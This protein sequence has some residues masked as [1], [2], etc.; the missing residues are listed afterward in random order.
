MTGLDGLRADLGADA[1]I[2][3]PDVLGAH[4][5]DRAL[6]DAG[7]PLALVR[8]RST[9]D[10]QAVLSWASATGT[11]VVTRGAGT[12][13]SGAAAA[14]EGSV[15]V[16][17][18][19]GGADGPGAADVG[20]GLLGAGLCDG[21]G[22]CGAGLLVGDVLL[23]VDDAVWSRW[24]IRRAEPSKGRFLPRSVLIPLSGTYRPTNRNDRGQ[25]PGCWRRCSCSEAKE[26]ESNPYR[27]R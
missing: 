18:E 26:P 7:W 19:A 22:L 12:G 24:K 6:T 13:L 5:Q 2:T 10:V 17:G 14:V 3:D 25:P 20:A 9:Q 27:P 11:P 21:A 8:P 23:A 16:V 4:R 1:V 15:A